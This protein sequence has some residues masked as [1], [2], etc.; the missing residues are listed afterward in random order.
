M[1]AGPP[2]A[3]NIRRQIYLPVPPRRWHRHA[4]WLAQLL[5]TGHRMS[6]WGGVNRGEFDL[7][8]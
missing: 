4:A 7:R 8:Q 2:D 6:V 1:L 5:D 3:S